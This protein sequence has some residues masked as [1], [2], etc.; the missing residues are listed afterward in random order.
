MT[1][2]C[3]TGVELQ[4]NSLDSC[5]VILLFTSTATLTYSYGFYTD[6]VRVLEFRRLG[7]FAGSW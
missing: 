5:S 3:N 7:V 6:L 1:A 2:S 4:K